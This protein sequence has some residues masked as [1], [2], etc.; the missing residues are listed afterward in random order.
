[1]YFR[2]NMQYTFKPVSLEHFLFLQFGKILRI[3]AVIQ[4]NRYISLL[5]LL[6]NIWPFEYWPIFVLSNTD[7]QIC[8][9]Q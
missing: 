3:Y 1:V 2:N 5:I 8:T 9:L 7:M 6:A 4:T